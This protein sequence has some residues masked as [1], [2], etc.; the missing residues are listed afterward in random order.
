MSNKKNA[1]AKLWLGMPSV[2]L[3]Q[4]DKI[5]VHVD[6]NPKLSKQIVEEAA[7]GPISITLES[8]DVDLKHNQSFGMVEGS[9]GCVSN[10]GGPSC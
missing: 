7:K 3:T 8:L 10:P 4:K 5:S 6:L 9:T 2:E 1:F